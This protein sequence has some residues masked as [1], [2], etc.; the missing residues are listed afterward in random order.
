MADGKLLL[1]I[2]T[3]D[4]RALSTEVDEVRAPGLQGGFGVRTGHTPFLSALR[5]GELVYVASGAEHHLAIG[6]GFAQVSDNRVLVLTELAERPE[7]IDVARAQSDA[8]SATQELTTATNLD[9][10]TYELRRAEVERAAARISVARH[11]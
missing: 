2:V 6:T 1:E 4:R 11:V 5:P 8:A 7:Q 3:P 10:A 9:D